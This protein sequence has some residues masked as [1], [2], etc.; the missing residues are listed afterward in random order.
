MSQRPTVNAVRAKAAPLLGM[1]ALAL[2]LAGCDKCSDFFSPA[3]SGSPQA[4][5]GDGP[6]IVLQQYQPV[7]DIAAARPVM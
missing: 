3:K 7:P 2:V 1:L 6:K 5:K 4:C